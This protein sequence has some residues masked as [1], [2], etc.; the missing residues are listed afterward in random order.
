MLQ[1]RD[2]VEHQVWWQLKNGNAYFWY[3]N[4]TGLGALYHASGPDHW[5]DESIKYVDKVVENGA[6]NDVLLSQL[7]PDELADHI[8]ETITPPLDLSIKD[9]P[10]WKLETKRHF[11]VKTS[12]CWCC[13]NPKEETL[14]HVFLTSP[15][16]R[17]VWNYYGAPSGIRTY[18]KQLM[19]LINEWWSKPVNTSLNA[20]YQ[21]MPSLIVWHLW[22][23]KNSGKHGKSVSINRLIFQNST[24]IQML[25][26]VRRP[27]F[28]GVTANWPDLHEKLS[29]HVPK[30]MYTKVLWE[31]PH[32]GWIKCNT[33]G[34]CRAV[35]GGASYGFCIRDGIGDIIYAHA[36]VVEDATN[37]V[38]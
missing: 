6:W 17:Y 16:A 12:R 5:C 2:E 31:L 28:E 20:V 11:T 1:I 18:R 10:W 34:A 9:K 21:A 14:P 19:Q 27:G 13:R 38:A 32:V 26:K 30:L 7:L 3:D 36:D 8:L 37:N 29:Q 22:K 23:K 24:S 25:L 4:W 33:D 35:N 15:A